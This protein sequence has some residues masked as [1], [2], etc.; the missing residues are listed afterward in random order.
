[1]KSETSPEELERLRNRM[2]QLDEVF[3]RLRYDYYTRTPSGAPA[4]TYEELKHA[5]AAFIE[6]SYAYQRARYGRIRLK[7]SVMKLLR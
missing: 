5:A 2:R 7:L 4:P 3:D 6:A 1:M